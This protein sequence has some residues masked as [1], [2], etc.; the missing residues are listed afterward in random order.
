MDLKYINFYA[1]S[2]ISIIYISFLKN[3]VGSIKLARSHTSAY[4][5]SYGW[6]KILDVF[7]KTFE[8]HILDSG[9]H[10]GICVNLFDITFTFN[11]EKKTY[12]SL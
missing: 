8:E 4:A 1:L 6:L 5:R 2:K 7:V 11:W 10:F 12:K 9:M 3:S